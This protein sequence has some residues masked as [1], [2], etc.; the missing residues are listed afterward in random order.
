MG[1]SLKLS[2]SSITDFKRGFQFLG[3]QFVEGMAIASES[4]AGTIALSEVMQQ[5]LSI[6]PEQLHAN[7]PGDFDHPGT[8][9]MVLEA[10]AKLRLDKGKLRVTLADQSTSTHSFAS[11]AAVLLA[12]RCKLSSELIKA[13]MRADVPIYFADASMHLRGSTAGL[14]TAQQL[15][16]WQRQAAFCGDLKCALPI[17]HA[18]VAAKLAHQ[19]KV[20]KQR[21]LDRQAIAHLQQQAAQ[22]ESCQDLP[23]LNGLE[24]EAAKAYFRAMAH[25]LPLSFPYQGRSRPAR[26]AV[27]CLLNFGYSFLYRAADT[28]ACAHGLNSK[29]GAMHQARPG[30]TALA[31]DLLEPMR[32]VID[33]QVWTMLKRGEFKSTDFYQNGAGAVQLQIE[34]R[35]R[36]AHALAQRFLEPIRA[37]HATQARSV[38]GHLADLAQAFRASIVQGVPFVVP[39]FR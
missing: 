36:F 31:S 11:L 7:S 32:F 5:A 35:R 17:A 8:L 10:G 29:I 1:L 16:F 12:A 19:V 24:G 2:K 21:Q 13:A 20:L 34:A 28:I 38:Y 3:Y 25:D 27:N 6:A 9:L 39:R 22:C 14:P 30:H 18:L 37:Q 4:K 23:A 15:K 26:D 33:S